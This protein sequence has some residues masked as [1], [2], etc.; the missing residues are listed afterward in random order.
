VTDKWS[1]TPDPRKGD[2]QMR[3]TAVYHYKYDAYNAIGTPTEYQSPIAC[4]SSYY[5]PSTPD[6]AKN[7]PFSGVPAPWNPSNAGRS[8]NGLV[9]T[10]GKTASSTDVTFGNIG[11]NATTGLFYDSSPGVSSVS[12]EIFKFKD[13]ARNPASNVLNPYGERLAYQA[14]L[15]FPN[16]RFVNEPLREVLKKIIVDK[17]VTNAPSAGLTLPQQSTLDANLCALQILDSHI[18]TATSRDFQRKCFP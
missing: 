12:S 9:Y 2:L 13:T 7:A 18:S 10:V 8:N 5:D 16:G 3:A 4:V 14:N 6:T 17:G 11:Y 1:A 15:M